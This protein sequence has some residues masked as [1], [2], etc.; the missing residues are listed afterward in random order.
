M[1]NKINI[2]ETVSTITTIPTLPAVVERISTLLKNPETSA[3]EIGRVIST[4]QALASKV[5]KL[6]NSAFYGFPGKISTITHAVVILGYA[7]IKNIALT[8][9][10]FKTLKR[11]D[12]SFTGFDLEKF[13]VHSI[14]CGTAAKTLA[15][16]C[17]YENPE[18]AFIAGL[19][20]DLGKIVF[21]Q[22]L[23]REF[24]QIIQLTQKKNI[25]I[26]DSEKELFGATHQEVGAILAQRWN[27]PTPLQS[28]IKYHHIPVKSKEYYEITAIVHCAD[29]LVRALDFGNSGDTKIPLMS[30]QAWKTLKLNSK[31]LPTLLRD[32]SDEFEKAKGMI[33]I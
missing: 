6:V 28:A 15:R 7:T 10:I 25:L 18:E 8:A 12:R 20:H 30:E 3:E 4:D 16:S 13:W 5:L 21:C 24:H 19:I 29:I 27:L 31:N 17:S 26:Y 32:I 14:A 9:S 2:L 33:E 11:N 23:P 1:E 22:Y